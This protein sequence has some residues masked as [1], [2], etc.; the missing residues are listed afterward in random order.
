MRISPIVTAALIALL[1]GCASIIE[2]TSQS[3]AVSTPPTEGAACT[4]SNREG[5]WQV[6]SPGVVTVRKSQDALSVRCSKPGW[7]DRGGRVPPEIAASYYANLILAP[8]GG[9]LIAAIVDSATGA[10]NK[11]PTDVQVPMQSVADQPPAVLERVPPRQARRLRASR[12]DAAA[13]ASGTA[14]PSQ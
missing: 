13:T 5:S 6:T 2:G 9:H 3:I 11:Y 14:D 4:L 1:P 7:T 8:T 12:P 10:I